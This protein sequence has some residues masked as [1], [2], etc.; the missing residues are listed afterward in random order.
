MTSWDVSVS[1]W[2]QPAPAGGTSVPGRW[3]QLPCYGGCPSGSSSLLVLQILKFQLVTFQ[4]V[5]F[6]WYQ[7]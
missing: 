1:V 3:W 4:T 6:L 2:A 5:P 7:C